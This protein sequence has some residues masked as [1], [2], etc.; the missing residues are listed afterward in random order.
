NSHACETTVIVGDSRLPSIRDAVRAE[1]ARLGRDHADCVILHP[2]YF[3]II[4]FSDHQADLSN[5]S[6]LPE[7]LEQ[8][9]RVVANA[10]DL[11]R[12]GRF[13]ALVV[14]DLYTRGEWIPLGFQCMEVCRQAGFQLKAI[15]VKDIQ[16]N[17]RGKGKNENLW[18]YR[19]LKL[20]FYI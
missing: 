4:R 9:A 10:H 17:E 3:D 6:T 14:G 12:P 20:G 8:F 5:A 11:L 7:F 16:G 1:I 18:R 15:N 19:A 13:M 2:P